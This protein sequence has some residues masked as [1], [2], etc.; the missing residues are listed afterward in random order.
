MSATERIKSII[1]TF[2]NLLTQPGA[3][4]PEQDFLIH[5]VSHLIQ[6]PSEDDI[7]WAEISRLERMNQMSL[8]ENHHLKE[9]VAKAHMRLELEEEKGRRRELNVE[10]LEIYEELEIVSAENK[11]LKQ[12]LKVRDFYAQDDEWAEAAS[13]KIHRLEQENEK[14]STDLKCL[15]YS[16]E[17]ERSYHQKKK[18]F[19]EETVV[20]LCKIIN[21]AKPS[22]D[23]SDD[24]EAASQNGDEWVEAASLKFTRSSEEENE[25]LSSDLKSNQIMDKKRSTYLGMSLLQ[26][27]LDEDVKD[28]AEDQDKD[29][30]E[31]N[32]KEKKKLTVAKNNLS[33]CF[34]NVK[35]RLFGHQ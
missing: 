26:A 4:S 35:K 18:Y 3:P 7:L 9:Q 19:L 17:M 16:M 30:A 21:E 32:G 25:K 20:E 14:L 12:H 31:C 22:S 23:Y 10:Q 27:A 1:E 8:Q 29:G 33:A 28:E 11:K 5:R 34:R 13:L 6:N 24:A 15:N 2:L